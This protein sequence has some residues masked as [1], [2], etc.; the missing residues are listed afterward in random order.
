MKGPPGATLGINSTR[1][2]QEGLAEFL[3]ASLLIGG[4]FFTPRCTGSPYTIGHV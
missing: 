3:V 2:A 1:D 4:D